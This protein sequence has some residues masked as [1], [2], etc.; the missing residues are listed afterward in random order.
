MTQNKLPTKK[1]L[2][3]QEKIKAAA[4]ELFII[5]GYQETGICDIIKLSGGSYSNI[6]NHF[7]NKEGLFFEI[8][9][10]M[11]KNHYNMITSKFQ[12]FKNE[13]LK[14][15]LISFGNLFLEIFN[16]PKTIAL[17]KI[18][19]SISND[20]KKHIKDWIKN[21]QDNFAHKI[22]EQY[23]QKQ[24]NSYLVKNSSKLAELFCT[25][26][27]EPNFTLSIIADNPP[28][29][30]KEQEKHINFIVEMFLRSVNYKV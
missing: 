22:L 26:L 14:E 28:L 17:G 19:H 6:Y 1:T 3:R 2:A 21:N 10:D 5:K 20:K 29:S 15:A 9:D 27:K 8:L 13:N 16:D 11:C 12:N 25:M 7:K 4:L 24:N 30:K 18:I 23:F